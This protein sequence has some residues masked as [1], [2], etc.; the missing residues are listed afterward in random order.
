MSVNQFADALRHGMELSAALENGEPE[1]RFIKGVGWVPS[2]EPP[3]PEAIDFIGPWRI[4][5]VDREPK[6]GE[7]HWTQWAEGRKENYSALEEIRS[8]MKLNY[9]RDVIMSTRRLED[10]ALNLP[11]WKETHNYARELN[12]G[13]RCIVMEISRVGA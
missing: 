8:A 6:I 1:Y 4:R 2:F 13:N 7:Y 5:Y 3:H 10:F 11:V 12:N 9:W